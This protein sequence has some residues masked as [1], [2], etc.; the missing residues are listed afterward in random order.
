MSDAPSRLHQQEGL[1]PLSPLSASFPLKK[2]SPKGLVLLHEVFPEKGRRRDLQSFLS[3]D[4]LNGLDGDKVSLRRHEDF[5]FGHSSGA[6]GATTIGEEGKEGS[7]FAL[8]APTRSM[9]S[10]VAAVP[11]MAVGLV[12]EAGPRLWSLVQPVVDPFSDEKEGD[13]ETGWCRVIPRVLRVFYW[14]DIITVATVAHSLYFVCDVPLRTWLLGGLFL[15]F[16]TTDLVHRLVTKDDPR[17][18]VVRFTI[19]KIRGAAD[20]ENFSLDTVVLYN[21]CGG[22]IHRSLVDER[23]EANYWFVDIREGP[24]LITAYSIV[25]HRTEGPECDPVSWIVEGSVDGVTW[26]MMDECNNESL[27]R[28]RE[29]A[30]QQF[31]DLMHM[32]DAQ[33]AFRQGFLAEVAACAGSFAWLVLGTSWVSAGTEAC[34]DSAPYLWYWAYFLV[35]VLWSFLGTV[36]IGLITCAVAM[37]IVG[38]KTP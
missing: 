2:P 22:P 29:A 5:L 10:A 35:V 11:A 30:S 13:K 6:S 4:G 19:K 34:V 17:T 31:D 25:T 28:Q 18:K 37:I 23:R 20:P 24:E 26:Y 1:L 36:T 27:P 16:P 15:G 38:G 3:L 9:M 14:S 21:R 12:S 7:F 33:A 8:P 32:P